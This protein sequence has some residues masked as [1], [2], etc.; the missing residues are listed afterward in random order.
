MATIT[1]TMCICLRT[2][3]V[4][5]STTSSIRD[6]RELILFDFRRLASAFFSS[7]SASFSSFRWDGS[8]DRVE[9]Y[10]SFHSTHEPFVSLL[11]LS[12]LSH[13]NLFCA[14]TLPSSTFF[15]LVYLNHLL[16]PLF[17]RCQY[18][19]LLLVPATF[20]TDLRYYY[21]P[22]PIPLSR[23]FPCP[24]PVPVRCLAVYYLQFVPIL[25]GTL[26]CLCSSSLL[27]SLQSS[28]LGFSLTTPTICCL[29]LSP[30]ST[31]ASHPVSISVSP[32]LGL[33]RSNSISG[34]ISS[35]DTIPSRAH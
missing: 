25:S 31:V 22:R 16:N 28:C 21:L 27:C 33:S 11:S 19:H 7:F 23:L 12:L 13:S 4:S 17:G 2:T 10:S 29:L 5:P 6:C 1:T 30:T 34:M 35:K 32:S 15:V 26:C 8:W 9:Y 24:C 18:R 20:S 14:T 3:A